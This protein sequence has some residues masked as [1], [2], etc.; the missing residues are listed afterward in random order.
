[1]EQNGNRIRIV[2]GD[3][4]IY[5]GSVQL[6][7]QTLFRLSRDARETEPDQKRSPQQTTWDGTQAPLCYLFQVSGTN[8]SLKQ[9]V[10]FN[11]NVLATDTLAVSQA[12]SNAMAAKGSAPPA[13]MNHFRL[14]L[15]NSRISG[16]A[17]INNLETRQI[18]AVPATR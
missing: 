16:T 15:E 18:N 13:L 17:V 4:S 1:M 7:T 2:D 3:G 6:A 10:T 12:W 8:R 9:S 11:G 5:S 14:P